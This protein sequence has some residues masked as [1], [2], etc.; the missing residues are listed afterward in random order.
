MQFQLSSVVAKKHEP[1]KRRRVAAV[2][3]VLACTG[4]VLSAC[5]SSSRPVSKVRSSSTKTSVSEASAGVK[6]AAAFVE[7]YMGI[8]VYPKD[9]PAFDAKAAA[10]KLIY[11]IP[12][13]LAG[14]N[15][16][17]VDTAEAAAKMVGAR[18]VVW[19]STGTIS[20]YQQ[21][22]EAAI[23]AGAN[24][25]SLEG[26]NPSLIAPQLAQARAKGIKITLDI[27][28]NGSSPLPAGFS[29]GVN[30]PFSLAGE[31]EADYAIMA[32]KGRVDALV[33]TSDD[34]PQT[35]DVLR[36]LHRA[37]NENCSSCTL[38]YVNETVPTWPQ[39]SSATA[40]ALR[41]HPNVNYVI[42]IYD[43]YAQFAL[44]G[45]RL[46]GM[47]TKVHMDSLNGTP[48]VL[49]TIKPGSVMQMDIGVSAVWLGWAEMTNA[50]RVALGYR[51]TVVSGVPRVFTSANVSQAGSPPSFADGYG[52]NIASSF[53]KLWGM[54]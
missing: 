38:H 33:L 44:S 4:L 25:I 35:P 26:T 36:G 6:R 51:P 53:E 1:S 43:N 9:G 3:A 30:M 48:S 28:G 18:A 47:S 11:L 14:F 49:S 54:G 32:T 5:S 29:G 17:I 8:P 31:L 39:F 41:Q 19:P 37:F 21:G 42:P 46:A 12:I 22:V 34:I 16:T 27:F 52:F 13:Q 15:K 7:K 45:I 40:A 10:G 20:S 24:V 50:L 2:L 23:T